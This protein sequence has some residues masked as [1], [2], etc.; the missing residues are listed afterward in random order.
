MYISV[1]HWN[2]VY[3]CSFKSKISD[4]CWI[5]L[6]I[7]A[8]QR[9]LYWLVIQ[10]KNGS[11]DWSILNCSL[12]RPLWVQIQYLL[13]CSS[14]KMQKIYG[15]ILLHLCVDTN[16]RYWDL[17]IY[18]WLEIETGSWIDWCY[19]NRTHLD[20]LRGAYKR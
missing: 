9:V 3:Q 1:R 8:S 15:Y 16:K 11:T 14:I 12:I 18:I 13:I 10:K 19:L 7:F 17:V 6:S 2:T 20:K 4:T 5:P